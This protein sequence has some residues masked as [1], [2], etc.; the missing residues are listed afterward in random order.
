M[1]GHTVLDAGDA[2]AIVVVYDGACPLCSREI[3][4]YR[5]RSGAERLRWVDATRELDALHE[6]GID[7]QT[8]L[9]KFHVRDTSGQWQIGAYG[10]ALLW[11]QLQ[12]YVWLARFVRAFRLLPFLDLA[13]RGFLRWRGR[14]RCD[15]QGCGVE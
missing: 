9:A 4:H 15:A 11:S 13:Y 1:S 3:A 6:L 12:P 7:Q 8:A 5:R 10:F 2:S 14:R